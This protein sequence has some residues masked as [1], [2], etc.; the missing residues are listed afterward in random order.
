MLKHLLCETQGLSVFR[1][2][3][4]IPLVF[5]PGA[6]VISK[7]AKTIK[8]GNYKVTAAARHNLCLRCCLL[9]GEVILSR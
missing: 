3:N 8:W 1:F 7:V 6:D 9:C 4:R 2:A 5:E